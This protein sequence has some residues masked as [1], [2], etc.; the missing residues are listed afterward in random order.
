MTAYYNLFTG[1]DDQFYFSLK[2]GN[3]EI[4]L[5]SEGYQSKQGA[6][7]GIESVQVNSS[8]ESNYERKIAND[9]S[10]YFILKAKN[11]EP[12]G[13]SEMYSSTQAME[14]GIE[15]VKSNGKTVKVKGHED[16]SINIILNKKPYKVSSE[17]LTGSQILALG[18]YSSGKYCLFLVKGNEQEEVSSDETVSLKN[19]MKFQAIVS[20]IKFG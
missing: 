5:Q 1:K 19:G 16:K 2:A 14:N 11:G 12:I 17:T 4:I 7:N 15:S 13:K 3:H 9:G 8:D 18:G 10:P 20:D 6:L